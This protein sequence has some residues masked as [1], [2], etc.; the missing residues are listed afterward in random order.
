MTGVGGD[1]RAGDVTVLVIDSDL[2]DANR[3][4]TSL[5]GTDVTDEV[6]L[7]SEAPDAIDV[8][9][10]RGEYEA[11]SRP[12][13]VLLDLDVDDGRGEA[14]LEEIKRDETLRRIPVIVCT[15]SAAERDVVRSYELH[16]NAFVQKPSDPDRF[17]DFARAIESFWLG[18]VQLPPSEE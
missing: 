13:L 3:I 17:D 5:E 9:Q 7:V 2:D 15:D 4:A 11:A 6:V 1:R 10:Q 16:A 18:I 8:L 14:V 12:N